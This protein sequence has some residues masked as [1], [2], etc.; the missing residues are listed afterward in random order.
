MT[1]SEE[2]FRLSLIDDI[3][4]NPAL[5]A[6]LDEAA[7]RRITLLITAALAALATA[8]TEKARDRM[9]TSDQAA[10]R[11]GFSRWKLYKHVSDY[12]FARR[13]GG[14]WVFSEQGID[15]W[16]AGKR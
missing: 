8:P 5:A 16:I 3:F 11:L 4:A 14:R 2:L 1:F 13:E 10:E 6:T 15:A 9:L 7:R 12:P